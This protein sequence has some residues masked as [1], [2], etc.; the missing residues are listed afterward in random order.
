MFDVNEKSYIVV[1]ISTLENES[2]C[3]VCKYGHFYGFECI[4]QCELFLKC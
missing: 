4:M 1:Y 3:L 2:L